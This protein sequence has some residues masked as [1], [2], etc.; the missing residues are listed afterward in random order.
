MHMRCSKWIKIQHARGRERD[1]H[2]GNDFLLIEWSLKPKAVTA[3]HTRPYSNFLF[4]FFFFVRSSIRFDRTELQMKRIR[5]LFF[6]III[7]I[8]DNFN[9]YLQQLNV[10]KNAFLQ[11]FSVGLPWQNRNWFDWIRFDLKFVFSS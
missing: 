6:E 11:K 2:N 10:N 9:H 4:I 5:I 8:K 7:I 1:S 3:F